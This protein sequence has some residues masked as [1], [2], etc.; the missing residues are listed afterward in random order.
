M[1]KASKQVEIAATILGLI[2]IWMLIILQVSPVIGPTHPVLNPSPSTHHGFTAGIY[3]QDIGFIEIAVFEAVDG[4]F[5]SDTGPTGLRRKL[6]KAWVVMS[7]WHI[8][9]AMCRRFAAPFGECSAVSFPKRRD[10]EAEEDDTSRQVTI[11]R[12]VMKRARKIVACGPF[13]LGKT[14]DAVCS[15]LV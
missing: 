2:D 4:I 14:C 10:L 15:T 12:D 7:T 8:D 3:I 13:L 9:Q 5:C 1:T 6:D 11:R